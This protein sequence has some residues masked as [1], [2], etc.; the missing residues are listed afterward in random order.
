M[1]Q[2]YVAAP[3]AVGCVDY[4]LFIRHLASGSGPMMPEYYRR[5]QRIV[6]RRRPSQRGG[7]EWNM[8][9]YAGRTL[10]T[11]LGIHQEQA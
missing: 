11:L 7:R 10:A 2:R 9:L 5:D 4:L 3:I 1:F 8:L 6:D